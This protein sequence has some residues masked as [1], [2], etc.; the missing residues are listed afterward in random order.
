MRWGWRRAAAMIVLAP[1]CL[2]GCARKLS[3]TQTE[4][5]NNAMWPAAE[6]SSRSGEPLELNIVCVYPADLNRAENS[7]LGPDKGLTSDIWFRDRPILGDTASTASR[8]SRF[9]LPSDQIF[10]MSNDTTAFGTSVGPALRGARDDGRA[11]FQVEFDFD[12]SIHHSQSVIY[13]FGKFVDRHGSVLPVPPAK[14]NP[15]G[16][17]KASIAVEVGCNPQQSVNEGQFIRNTTERR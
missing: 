11:T 10:V 17:Y 15:P 12:G 4:F 5:V 2:T 9:W 8:G 6:R 14:W 1:I 13:V 7:R 3:I 16:D